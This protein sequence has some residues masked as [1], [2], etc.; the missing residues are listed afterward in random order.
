MRSSRSIIL[1][2]MTVGVVWTS[3]FLYVAVLFL[4]DEHSNSRNPQSESQRDLGATVLLVQY[5]Q[6]TSRN[7]KV[8][9][10]PLFA[11]PFD[12]WDG[13]LWR[14]PINAFHHVGLLHLLMNGC[15]MLYMGKLLEPRLGKLRTLL[16]YLIAATVTGIVPSLLGDIGVGLSGVAYA[17][18][19][20]LMVWRDRDE[21]VAREFPYSIVVIAGIWLVGCQLV[22]YADIIHI[23]NAAHYS[24]LVYGWLF[25][26]TYL[27]SVKSPL[28]RFLFVVGHVFLVPAF[29]FAMN[30]FWSGDWH[31]YRSSGPDVSSYQRLERLQAAVLDDPTLAGAWNELTIEFLRMHDEPAAFRVALEG[32]RHNPDDSE[33]LDKL[34]TIWADARLNSKPLDA[35]EFIRRT[36]GGDADRWVEMLHSKVD[37]FVNRLNWTWEELEKLLDLRPIADPPFSV[38][39]SQRF[40]APP[41]DPD[42]PESALGGVS[43]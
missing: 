27:S 35:D 15:A 22:T 3:C 36:F 37:P 39:S 32:F 17:Q 38:E 30:P 5:N 42:A 33:I 4:V 29:W 1:A 24:G 19:G 9:Q 20:L 40:S 7:G 13:Q 12:L 31:W 34:V 16:F 23:G 14:V 41:T 10:V 28:P 6:I 21:E 18:V 26:Q 25:G 2:P 8:E 11:G 43:M